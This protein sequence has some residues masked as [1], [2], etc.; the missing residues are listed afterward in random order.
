[1]KLRCPSCACVLHKTEPQ[2]YITLEESVYGYDND[3]L[4]PAYYCRNTN[5]TTQGMYW[6]PQGECHGRLL[7]HYDH[8]I[9]NIDRA[10]GSRA[11]EVNLELRL[12]LKKRIKLGNKYMINELKPIVNRRSHVKWGYAETRFFKEDDSG[13][14]TVY[15]PVLI[16]LYTA[17][18]F[19][20][21]KD[22]MFHKY[23][24]MTGYGIT[25]KTVI[26]LMKVLF[27]RKYKKFLKEN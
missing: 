22:I 18:K 10:I 26:K 15:H 11:R 7:G 6:S 23:V 2:V 17:L 5:C 24:F 27:S 12:I 4:R 20:L 25:N 13:L 8:Y 21:K 19:M 1:M 3:T 9:N 16:Q 14:L